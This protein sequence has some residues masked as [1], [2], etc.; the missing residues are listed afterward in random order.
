VIFFA[1]VTI[2]GGTLLL[3]IVCFCGTEFSI[4][5]SLDASQRASSSRNEDTIALPRRSMLILFHDQATMIFQGMNQMML[6]VESMR[7][8]T[9][10]RTVI[11]Q[12]NGLF[13]KYR[14]NV[15]PT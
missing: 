5:V 12:N 13:S 1:F 8:N 6:N 11:Q 2:F 9:R 7:Q 14:I 4:V 10:S 15:G 3:C